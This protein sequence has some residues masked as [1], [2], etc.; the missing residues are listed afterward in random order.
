MDFM[1]LLKHQHSGYKRKERAYL[2]ARGSDFES[3]R[4]IVFVV[5]LVMDYGGGIRPP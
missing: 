1:E 5:F 2:D 3:K 4:K